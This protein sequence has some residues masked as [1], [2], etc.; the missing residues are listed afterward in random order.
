MCDKVLDVWRLRVRGLVRV[1]CGGERGTGVGAGCVGACKSAR[2]AGGR[3]VAWLMAEQDRTLCRLCRIRQIRSESSDLEKNVWLCLRSAEGGHEA[4]TPSVGW[5]EN[6]VAGIPK[7]GVL[8]FYFVV[9]RV[10]S[11][12]NGRY[13][14][15]F[16]A[17]VVWLG[18]GRWPRG[19]SYALCRDICINDVIGVGGIS[20]VL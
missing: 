10:I 13:E 18:C 6:L 19:A 4:W 16:L 5:M 14:K 3:R 11:F 15:A 17:A 8:L 20:V 1:A 2:G 9:L 12:P 7:L